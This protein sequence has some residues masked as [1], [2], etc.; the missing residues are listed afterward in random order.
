M[1][2]TD[3]LKP[4][5]ESRALSIVRE[6]Y[7]AE[8]RTLKLSFAS[9]VAVRRWY[10]L[11]ILS[12]D[13]EDVDLSRLMDSAPLLL[14]HDPEREKHVGVVRSASVDADKVCRA[15][16][17]LSQ[18]D[19]VKGVVQDI[20]DGILVKASVGY[21]TIK[22]LSESFDEKTG[23]RTIRWSW[24][25]YEISL[26]S[27]PADTS[28]GVGRSAGSEQK[29]IEMNEKQTPS[30][31]AP[32]PVKVEVIKDNSEQVRKDAAEMLK[33][34]R[35][36]NA[37]ELADKALSEGKSLDQ[38]R[39][40]LLDVVAKRSPAP[41][42]SGAADLGL[43][44]KEKRTYSFG[45]VIRALAGDRS[46]DA[47]F[48]LELSDAAA[49][50]QGKSARG[51]IVPHDILV[52]KRDLTIGGGGTG[53]NLVATNLLSGSF[54]ERLRNRLV[55][56]ELGAGMLT[57]LVGDVAIP[58]HTTETTAYWVTEGNAPT[59][60]LPVLGQVTGTPHTVAAY[61]DASRKLL[62]QSSIDV[63]AIIRDDLT[64]SLA[65]AIDSAAINGTGADGQPSGLLIASG[66]NNPSVSSA[67][68]ATYA[69]ILA[70][71]TDIEADNANVGEVAWAMTPEVWGNLAARPKG[72]GDGFILDADSSRCI[73]YRA[74][75]S[76]QLPANTAILGVW[77]QLVIGMWGG[78]DLTVDNFSLSTTGAVR[79]VAFQD[80]DIMV[81]HAQAFAYNSAV[82]T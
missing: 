13:P 30:P 80:I 25:P 39:A 17:V 7:N 29:G 18:R 54:I 46:V 31:A 40:E 3:N 21:E 50:L 57:G 72:T 45:K 61:V 63:E 36:H 24:K 8:S 44:D 26:V 9:E 77:S 64:R 23:E 51:I 49:K 55:T 48:E 28:V 66:I 4:S 76:N 19:D 71:L 69:E 78:L 41:A 33:L 62:K 16:C 1:M 70:F 37:P 5:R 59:E 73:G 27:V 11:E 15:E 75:M 38:F 82:T 35:A 65:I 43:S 14:D 2:T 12:C 60:G 6:G 47:S 20:V 42:K 68:S 53:S 56:Q 67:G 58:K 34:A 10:G 22:L 32:E 79:V 74:I 52:Q 81:R